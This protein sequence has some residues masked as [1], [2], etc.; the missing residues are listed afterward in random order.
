MNREVNVR[1][2]TSRERSSGNSRV[3][4]VKLR[5]GPLKRLLAASTLFTMATASSSVEP[6]YGKYY[7][8]PLNQTY[9]LHVG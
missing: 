3:R 8:I 9:R 4:D 2:E 1:K 6:S 5:K 7:L